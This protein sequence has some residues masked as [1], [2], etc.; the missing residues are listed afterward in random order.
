MPD[1]EQFALPM[2]GQCRCGR[3]RYKV[4]KPPSFII[5]CHCTDCQQLT[6]SAFSTG[7]AVPQDGFT[8]QGEPDCWERTADSGGWSRQF[9][10]PACKGWTH[11]RTQNAPR[12]VVVRPSTLIDHSWVRPIAQI[13]TASALPWA[14][15]QT[16]LSFEKEFEDPQQLE[17]AFAASGI[18]PG[19]VSDAVSGTAQAYQAAANPDIPKGGA[20][21]P[22]AIRKDKVK[23][24]PEE[25]EAGRFATAPHEIPLQGVVARRQT[26]QRRLHAGPRHGGSRQRHILRLARAVPCNSCADFDLRDFPRS[27]E[28]RPAARTSRQFR[29]EQRHGTR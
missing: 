5:A 20:P 7:M 8:L 1:A 9:T 17:Q 10:C 19:N 18:A 27:C 22:G 15:L 21:A 24:K 25:R 14:L 23:A 28:C 12:M 16:S 29:A 11:T 2:A 26:R 6:S 3:I 4:T 13:F